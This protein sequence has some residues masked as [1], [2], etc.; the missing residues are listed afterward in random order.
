MFGLTE[1]RQLN[2][3][4]SLRGSGIPVARNYE[5][6]KDAL[7]SAEPFRNSRGSFSAEWIDGAYHVFSYATEIAT[8]EIDTEGEVVARYI[9][10]QRYSVTTSKQVGYVRCCLPEIGQK[11]QDV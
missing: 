3:A 2:R 5:D 4:H 1:I 10:D 11:V 6:C 9:T 8:L 7:R